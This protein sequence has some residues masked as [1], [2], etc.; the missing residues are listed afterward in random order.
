MNIR[1]P[2]QATLLALLASYPT[3]PATET[4]VLGAK[5]S[6]EAGVNPQYM[7]T[8][9]HTQTIIDNYT[10]DCGGKAPAIVQCGG[11]WSNNLVWAT[12][13]TATLDGI[14]SRGAIPEITWQSCDSSSNQPFNPYPT[15]V[16]ASGQ[17]SAI[18]NYITSYATALKNYSDAHGGAPILLRFDHEMNG[19]WYPWSTGGG[20]S[21][22]P[23]STTAN[24]I[25]AWKHVH[26]RFV[27]IGATNVR[28]VFCVSKEDPY[29]S[30]IAS[31]FPG[32]SYVDWLAF[33]AYNY[34]TGFSNHPEGW[35]NLQYGVGTAYSSLDALGTNKPMIINEIGCGDG[36]GDKGAW[37]TQSLMQTIPTVYPKVQ[38]VSWF[39]QDNRPNEPDWR[40]NSSTTAQTAYQQVAASSLY[41]GTMS[42][43]GKHV[44]QIM[45]EAESLTAADYSGPAPR[46]FSAT[47]FSGGQGTIQDSIAVGNY[48]TYN[49]P[50]IPA[51]TY[52]VRVGVKKAFNR[53]IWQLAIGKADSFATTKS[54]VGTPQDE[55][56]PSDAY[57]ELN[58][59]NWSPSSTSDK[60]FQF[61]VTGKNSSSAGYTIAFDYIKLIPQ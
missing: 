12:L 13:N 46:V 48:V 59:G 51:G 54:N 11:C 7:D 1:V 55:Y 42:A 44:A 29:G 17:N 30:S 56:A 57:P 43:D 53:G 32:S 10:A 24:Y 31:N 3:A 22:V 49:L 8:V 6:P 37:I 52:N 60:W 19:W 50:A 14:R 26:D 2:L 25:A 39:D 61:L 23:S 40:I 21:G 35:V 33:D 58:L 27:A 28:W 9:A 47:Q 4:L 20:P 15:S 45:Y 5:I 36:G 41:A 34:G 38:V 16:I 18:E